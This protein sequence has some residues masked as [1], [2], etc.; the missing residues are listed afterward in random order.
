MIEAGGSQVAL[1]LWRPSSLL[2][3]S[4]E[5]KAPSY[6]T[7]PYSDGRSSVLTRYEGYFARMVFPT[8]ET[9]PSTAP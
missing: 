1:R 4:A 9:K 7:L 3:D 2:A 8:R 5:F 6:L